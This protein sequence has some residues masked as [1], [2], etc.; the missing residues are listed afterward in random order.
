MR[1]ET[2]AGGKSL[3]PTWF[4]LRIRTSYQVLGRNLLLIVMEERADVDM[5]TPPF[6]TTGSAD[7]APAAAAADADTGTLIVI[8]DCQELADRSFT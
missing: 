2:A 1:K 6:V 5:P 3:E 7:T 8:P 4:S